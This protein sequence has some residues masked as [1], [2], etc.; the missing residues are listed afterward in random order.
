MNSYE[1]KEQVMG[2]VRHILTAGGGYFVGQGLL[3]GDMMVEIVAGVV[4]LVGV[5]WS[6]WN[7]RS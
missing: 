3:T 5:V 4:T 6:V 2:V 1:T 7:K